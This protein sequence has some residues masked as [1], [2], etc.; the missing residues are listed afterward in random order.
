MKGGEQAVTQAEIAET[1]GEHTGNI[2]ELQRW[3]KRQNGSL[4]K[5][6]A[7]LG[8]LEFLLALAVGLGLVNLVHALHLAL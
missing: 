5:I 1:I 7:R 3:Q 4:Q 8:R 6:E 2:Q